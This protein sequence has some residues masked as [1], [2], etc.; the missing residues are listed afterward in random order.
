MPWDYE[1]LPVWECATKGCNWEYRDAFA[2]ERDFV[3]S[4][5]GKRALRLR[6]SQAALADFNRVIDAMV[7]AK[8]A[9]PAEAAAGYIASLKRHTGCGK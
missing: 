5:C 6:P 8:L 9:T 7:E 4:G 2:R 1:E 3:C